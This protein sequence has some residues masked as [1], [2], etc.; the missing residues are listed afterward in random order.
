MSYD[1]QLLGPRLGHDQR[2]VV[3]RHG[4]AV[5]EREPVRHLADPAVG[6]DER[7][8]PGWSVLR[9]AEEPAVD[10]G[11]A[12]AV[13][14]ELVPVIGEVAQVGVRDEGSVRFEA[15]EPLSRDQEATVR[16]PV[17]RPAE[18]ARPVT[19]DL[20]GAIEIDGDDLVGP[21]V[22]EP[23]PAVMPAWRLDVG[24]TAQDDSW[25]RHRSTPGPT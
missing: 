11:V 5:R 8:D 14:D 9:R 25:L 3:G 21:P 17:D 24:E 19:D 23:Q 15:Q 10:V 12:A 4:H 20:A 22:G 1:G 6:R 13:D 18:A 2:P 7:D 16:Q